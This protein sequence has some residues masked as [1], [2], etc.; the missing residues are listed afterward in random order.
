MVKHPAELYREG[1]QV[2]GEQRVSPNRGHGPIQSPVGQ[3]GEDECHLGPVRPEP[4]RLAADIVI[5]LLQEAPTL[6]K[7]PRVALGKRRARFLLGVQGLPLRGH[8][9]WGSRKISRGG[10]GWAQAPELALSALTGLKA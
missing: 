1:R 10:Q 4:G 3:G 7:V 5:A 6:V 9:R 8:W 2:R